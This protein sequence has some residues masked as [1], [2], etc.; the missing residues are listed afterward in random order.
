MLISEKNKILKRWPEHFN[1]VLNRLS[2]INDKAIDWLP[3]VPVNKPLDIT[4]ILRE[5][6]V[7]IRQLSGSKEPI[8]DSIPVEIYNK[9]G[10]ALTDKILT[11]IQLIPWKKLLLQDLK[12]ASIIH[13]YKQKDNQQVCDN[14]RG[15]SLL[16]ISSKIQIKFFRNRINNHLQ[17]ELLPENQCDFRKERGTVYMVFVAR[18]LL[19]KCQEKSTDL[20]S[21][22]DLIKASDMVSRDN[23]WRIMTKYS[24]PEKFIT[25]VRQ[26]HDGKHVKVEDNGKSSVAFHVTNEVNH[27]CVLTPIFLSILFYAMLFDTLS[28]SDY[29]IN[30]R[31]HTVGSIF[32]CRRLEG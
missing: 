3:Q 20:Y 14:L 22:F 6:Q 30:I 25:I 2:S 21:T 5:V 1:G 17:R 26:F 4:P 31:Y 32:N 7:T 10:S 28:G 27:W 24:C 18:Q 15:I 23:L 16:S 9:R 11:L 29:G 13:I 12:D 8:S 19:E